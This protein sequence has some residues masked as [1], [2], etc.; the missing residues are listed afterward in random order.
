MRISNF[1]KKV[2]ITTLFLF[3]ICSCERT[4]QNGYEKLEKER[5]SL[6]VILREV[7]S[8]Y[9]FDSVKV[10]TIAN[11]ENS[12]TVNSD[13]KVE[14]YF[15]GYNKESYFVDYDTVVNGKIVSRDTLKP[16]KGVFFYSKKLTE[17]KNVVE[18]YISTNNKHGKNIEGILYSEVMTKE[19]K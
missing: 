17:G 8:K 7:N 1:F 19:K 6:L 12:N 9:I 14:F 3:T 16:K 11:P 13:F 4:N 2:F 10:K 15:I 5:D 18:G